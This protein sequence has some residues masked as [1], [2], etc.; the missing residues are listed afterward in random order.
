MQMTGEELPKRN[1]VALLSD[2]G[3]ESFYVGAMKA[4]ISNAAPEAHIV[5]V[6]HE[7]RPYAI[8]EGSFIL[9]SVFPFFPAGTIFLAVVDP[10]V[11]GNRNNLIFRIGDKYLIAPDNGLIT[12]LS[13]VIGMDACWK[14]DDD[15][16]KPYRVHPPI[17]STFLGRDVFAPAAG[18]LAAGVPP[19]EIGTS[20]SLDVEKINV[21]PVTAGKNRLEGYGRHIDRF[22]NVLTGI[23]GDHLFDILGSNELA[24]IHARVGGYEINCV[25][26]CYVE[27]PQGQLMVVLNSWNLIEVSV[28]QGRADEALAISKPSDMHIILAI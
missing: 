18:A 16:I 21:P 15:R 1:C 27:E 22:G 25:R 20:A 10:G 11:G 13:S 4:V 19:D 23:T 5:D 28:S 12:D 17:G 8:D 14:I 9:S 3:F 24:G 26:G 2:F 7:V 6:T